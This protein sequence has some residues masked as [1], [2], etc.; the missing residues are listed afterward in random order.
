MLQFC[1][2]GIIFPMRFLSAADHFVRLWESTVFDTEPSG[3][4][5]RWYLFII[6]AFQLF[7]GISLLTHLNYKIKWFLFWYDYFTIITT[8]FR[9]F[10]SPQI[11][12]LCT[13]SHSPQSCV[14]PTSVDGYLKLTF[15]L[16]KKNCSILCFSFKW[17]HMSSTFIV[18]AIFHLPYLF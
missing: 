11:K 16:K 3:M 17:S 12:S 2:F 18:T 4:T 5:T 15:C 10:S 9:M 7:S 8:D 14:L 6:T 1:I 13:L